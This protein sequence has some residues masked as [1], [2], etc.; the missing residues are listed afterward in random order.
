MDNLGPMRS[1]LLVLL[2]AGCGLP[3]VDSAVPDDAHTRVVRLTASQWSLSVADLLALSKPPSLADG[4]VPDPTV[5]K[6]DNAAEEL[7]VTPTLHQQM[8]SA[9]IELAEATL[10]SKSRLE[11]VVGG[12][13]DE[14]LVDTWLARFGQRAFRRP[15]TDDE[16]ATYRAL[17]AE[18]PSAF[19]DATPTEAGVGMVIV[20]LLQSPHFLYRIEHTEPDH[21]TL[22]P[23]SFASRLSFAL[24]NGP[25]DDLLLT[26]ATQAD[27]AEDLLEQVPRML[28]DARAHEMV[29]DLHWQVLHVD[30]FANIPRG[31]VSY[32]DY[33]TTRS[34][35]MQE[36]VTRFV[37]EIVFGGGTVG[38]LF[39]RRQTEVDEQTAALYGLEGIEGKGTKAMQPVSLDPDERSGLLTMP[40]FLTVSSSLR[41]EN[42]IR[43]AAFVHESALCTELPP[44]PPGATQL[45]PASGPDETQRERIATHTASCGSVCHT[46]LIN[47]LAF[48]F[49][50]YDE[51]GRY[52]DDPDIDVASAFE[53]SFGTE[54]FDGAVELSEL[55]ADDEATHRCYASNLVRYLEGRVLEPDDVGRI[56]VLTDASLDDTQILDLIVRV[57]EHTRFR[58]LGVEIDP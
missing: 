53:F 20:G 15:L 22:R 14:L 4:F 17:F 38:D 40:G 44:P 31:F 26:A 7:V 37:D 29:R 8:M 10:R 34:A 5:G 1:A 35:V 58:E 33:S 36:E 56:D 2:L 9:A 41:A 48:A 32:E 24:W 6:F 28:A 23:L 42:L 51:K 46:Q 3:E 54:A 52:R 25:P 43:R 47:P 18:G 49:G 13:V 45:P 39:T 21:H 11:A 57:V 19:P 30:T 27:D 55:L 50:Q 16:V 12:P